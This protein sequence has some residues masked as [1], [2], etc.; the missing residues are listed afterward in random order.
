MFYSNTYF[1]QT[2]ANIRIIVGDR[3][4]LQFV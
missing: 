1:K 2:E 4:L 3:T